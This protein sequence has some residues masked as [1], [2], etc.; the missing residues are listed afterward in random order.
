[1]QAQTVRVDLRP[2]TG[3]QSARRLRRQGKLPGVLYG[4]KAGNLAV[5]IPGREL[6]HIL[7]TEG[8]NALLKLKITGGDQEK[9]FA[10]VIREIQRHP[11]KGN[12]THVDFY[13]VSLEDKLKATV[14]VVLEGEAR[15][16]KEGGILQH[17]AREIEVESLPGDLPESIVVDVSSLGI[18]EHLT[19]GDIKV[20]AGVKV[21]SDPDTIVALV[22]TTRAAD[23]GT[24]EETS[25]AETPAAPAE[26]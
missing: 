15:G 19:V 5:V 12:L 7:A 24:T 13:Q 2:Q 26:E 18:G 10:A 17:G 25:P 21:L 4:K 9:E 14:P 20:P 1:M 3:K 22:V 11:I 8:E 6:E 16:V 23:T